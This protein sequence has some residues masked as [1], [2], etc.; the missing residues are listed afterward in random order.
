MY[1]KM[2][3]FLNGN[4]P[5]VIYMF[6]TTPTKTTAA[7]Y[8]KNNQMILKFTRKCKGPRIAKSNLKQNT[9]GDL[10][11]PELKLATKLQQST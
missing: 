11:L 5:K 3:Y 4:D 8:P 6:Y 2:W 7:F 10:T 9:L 1:Q